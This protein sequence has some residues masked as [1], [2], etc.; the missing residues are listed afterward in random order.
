MP[1]KTFVA[2]LQEAIHEFQSE[3]LSNLRAG[4]E[5]GTITFDYATHDG[6][7]EAT[8]IQAIVPGTSSIPVHI[9]YPNFT[10][11]D[12]LIRF[13]SWGL[14]FLSW[15]SAVHSFV[16]SPFSYKLGPQKYWQFRGHQA[17]SNAL[18]GNQDPGRG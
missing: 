15:I 3:N 5:D 14:P 17:L 8:T 16:K 6:A 18:D 13:R 11:P 7:Y 2:D 4:D 12:C 9:T 10:E 1:R